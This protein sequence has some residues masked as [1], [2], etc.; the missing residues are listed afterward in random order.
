MPGWYAKKRSSLA[1]RRDE[2]WATAA[3]LASSRHL[4]SAESPM[5]RIRPAVS[6][7]T[8][9]IGGGTGTES[10]SAPKAHN[11]SISPKMALST[12]RTGLWNFGGA[13][14][15]SLSGGRSA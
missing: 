13:E 15:D 14:G 11:S 8:G 6:T 9:L 1:S 10:Q 5:C 2:T 4:P 12:H 3:G 7:Y